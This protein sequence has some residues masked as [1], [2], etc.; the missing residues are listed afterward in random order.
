MDETN[1]LVSVVVPIY[2]GAPYI[3]DAAEMIKA[4][5]Y[6]NLEVIFVNDGSQ[7]DS[8]AMWTTSITRS[9]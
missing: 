2:N 3:L 7:D 1:E 9:L 4:Q 8:A 5:T 6:S